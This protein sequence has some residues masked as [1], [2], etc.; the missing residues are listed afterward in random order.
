MSGF[1]KISQLIQNLKWG[2]A[3]SFPLCL[4]ISLPPPSLSLTHTH[5][6]THTQSLP[7]PLIPL[8]PLLIWFDSPSGPRP[9]LWE[10]TITFRH[11]TLSRTPLDDNRQRPLPDSA[12]YTQETDIR[13]P[14]RIRTRIPS[15]RAAADPRLRP[16]G[17][18]D[19]LWLPYILSKRK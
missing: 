18:W 15:K 3:V 8:S 14:G 12:R 6:H 10:S 1:V 11:A 13:D 19:R 9:P 17:R 7:S 4:F 5:T 16:R 2:N